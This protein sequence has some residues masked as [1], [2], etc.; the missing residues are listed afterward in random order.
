MDKVLTEKRLING[1][2]VIILSA[3]SLILFF[4]GSWLLPITDPTECCYTLTAKEMLSVGDW[5]SPR[6]YGDFWFDKPIMFYWELLVAYTIFGINEFASRFF[7]AFFATV[8]LFIT[9]F[10]GTKLYNNKIGFAA[11]LMLATTLE[12]WY[13]SHAIITDMTLMV[14]F[15][16]TLISFFFGY[17][18]G[19]P[20]LYM[21]SFAAS[22]V[23]VLTK[24]PIGFFLPG[25]IIL[26]FLLWQGDLK[27]LLKLFHPKNFLILLAIV[28]LWYLPMIFLHG[29][30]FVDNFLGVHNFL[31]ATVSEYPKTDVW[32]YYTLISVVGF[33]PW[34]LPLIPAAVMKLFH[35]VELFIEEGH[36]PTFD[37]HEKFLIVWALT[38]VIFFQMCATKYVTY[39]LPAMMPAAIFIARYFVNRWKIFIR[40]AIGA[41]IIF[42][43]LLIFVALPL[44]EDNS[45]RRE[46][47][48]ILPLV[49]KDTCVVSHG[50]E[51]S[52][53]L[54]HYSGLKIFRLETAE[55]FKKIR[56]QNLSWTSKNVMPFMTFDEMPI[57]GKIVAVVSA[58]F[59]KSFLDNAS[60]LWTC[61]G[62]V[63]KGALESWAEKFFYG[64]DKQFIKSKIYVRNSSP[65]K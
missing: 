62:E 14:A 52:G 59:E 17:R 26:I 47:E 27:H 23:A 49:D 36:L 20:N 16:I 50:K 34:S 35:R 10:F 29:Q 51:Y 3:V 45:G 32:Y 64:R 31:R 24:G 40:A 61:I 60:G 5:L 56:P 38:V 43:L 42:P 15:S 21:I 58:P 8:G 18:E 46:A 6:I 44:T 1:T 37:M 19:K 12:Y 13:L 7:P 41:V 65:N 11:A 2:H 30:N 39:T 25:L 9:Y 28:S 63:D 22:G 54:V 33:L 57:N 48:M 4:G 55:N 53:S